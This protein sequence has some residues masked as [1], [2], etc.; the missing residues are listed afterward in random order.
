MVIDVITYN[1]EVDLLEIRLNILH[2][3]VD[4][5]IIVEFTET[6]IGKPKKISFMNEDSWR[7]IRNPKW[8]KKVSLYLQKPED[9][10]KYKELAESSPNTKG[11]EHWKQEFMQKES[12]KDCIVRKHQ[13]FNDDDIV[14]IGDCDEIWDPEI[15]KG[16]TGTP[17]KLSLR[18]Y[19]YYL[20][21][22]SSEK[23][24]GTFLSPYGY[25]KDKCLNHL[26][27]N[28][29]RCEPYFYDGWHFT[30]MAH[31]LHQKLEDSYT[32]DS[33]AT[34]EVMA[35]L[36]RNIESNKDFLGRDFT[37]KVDESDWPPWL[38]ENREKF[39]HLLK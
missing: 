29:Y 32:E 25:I 26:R 38:K 27:T 39:A 31:Q 10:L 30:S 1:G 5:F 37:Y 6:F 18:V 12:I 34:P 17:C 2:Q 3:Y 35:N 15:L 22:R 13:P 8:S 19:T 36:Y 21:N 7:V 14:F 24:Y 16:Y 11:A 33:Y 4:K 20:N 23:F 28:A 9:W